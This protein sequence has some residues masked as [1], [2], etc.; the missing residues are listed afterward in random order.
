MA[1]VKTSTRA[2][3]NASQSSAAAPSRLSHPAKAS[4]AVVRLGL[5]LGSSR[6]RAGTGSASRC[7]ASVVMSS[8][9]PVRVSS[10]TVR[11]HTRS[12]AAGSAA[13][14]GRRPFGGRFGDRPGGGHGELGHALGDGPV[15]PL[16]EAVAVQQDQLARAELAGR[17]DRRRAGAQRSRAGALEVSGRPVDADDQR[18]R[19]PAGGI[20]QRAGGRVEHRQREGGGP[21]GR[22]AGGERIGA[23]QDVPEVGLRGEE[24]GQHGAQLP[25]RRGGGDPVSH[26]ITD[27]QRDAAVGQRDR[28]EPVA[29]G[30]LLLPGHQVPGRDPGPRQDRQRGRQ[31][32]FLQYRRYRPV[33]HAV[34]HRP[35]V[36]HHATRH[37]VIVRGTRQHGLLRPPRPG[38][39]TPV[40]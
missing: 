33:P 35:G 36:A 28:V 15:R 16:D 6:R 21:Q 23:L 3:C 2:R 29:A 32:R 14:A 9:R 31:Q 30:R 40:T 5:S 20:A 17:Q 34:P 11:W 10:S 22:R 26:H 39:P 1:L 7:A 13:S 38:A 18:R 37:V 19:M 8:A 4:R 24:F 27:D 12:A 25:H